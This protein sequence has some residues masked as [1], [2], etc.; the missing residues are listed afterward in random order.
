VSLG[1]R[2]LAWCVALIAVSVTTLVFCTAQNLESIS[3]LY[4]AIAYF[5][6]QTMSSICCMQTQILLDTRDVVTGSGALNR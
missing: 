3:V 4:A 5:V 2:V 1:F 6:S